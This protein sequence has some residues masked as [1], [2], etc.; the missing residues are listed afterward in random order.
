MAGREVDLRT[1]TGVGKIVRINRDPAY[2]NPSNNHRYHQTNRDDQRVT[3]LPRIPWIEPEINGLRY[4]QLIHPTTNP[5]TL[6]KA[7]SNGCIGMREGDVWRLYYFA[8][9]GT[10][11]NFRYE[12][13]SIDEHGNEIL[14]KHIYPPDQLKQPSPTEKPIA[15]NEVDCDC[16]CNTTS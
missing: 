11:V 10:K 7:Y 16:L 1:R 3:K 2:I 8:P 4:G 13:N 9:I 6:G 5:V 12:R 14:L 15:A